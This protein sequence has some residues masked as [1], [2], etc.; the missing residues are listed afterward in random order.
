MAERTNTE[1]SREADERS[2]L[3]GDQHSQHED[4]EQTPLL[5][6]SAEEGRS[7]SWYAWR[8]F[9]AI[10]LAVIIGVFIKGWIDSDETDVISYLTPLSPR[11]IPLT[12]SRLV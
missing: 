8:I 2:A 10:L 12:L 9:W 6:T 3:L 5:D 11:F 1:S 7:K 4:G